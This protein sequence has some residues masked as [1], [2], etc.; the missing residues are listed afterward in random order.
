MDNS[1]LLQW[2]ATFELDGKPSVELKNDAYYNLADGYV[3][4][5][6]LNQI[7][8]VY[9]PD[10][11]LSGIKPV[12]PNGSWPLRVSN[13]NRILQKVDDYASDL[14]DYQL[15]PDAKQL[16]VTVIA[17]NFDSDQV[18]K[19][20]QLILFCAFT[21]D[22]R[23]Y[24]VEKIYHL[25]LKV[26][27]DIK[28]AFEQIIIG[29]KRG[30]TNNRELNSSHA[31]NDSVIRDLK[32]DTG[33]NSSQK[34]INSSPI[35][36]MPAKS[37]GFRG[38]L[39][40]DSSQISGDISRKNESE[41]D[42][43]TH[44]N[45]DFSNETIEE[46]RSR[47][48]AAMIMKDEKS[49]AC[50]DLE[51]K[52]KQLQLEKDLLASENERLSNDKN[53]SKNISSPVN[54][55]S[56][57]RQSQTSARG[58][59]QDIDTRT[60][61]SR[62]K[63]LE[64]DNSNS[65]ILKQ[66]KKLQAELQ[67]LK[68]DMIKIESEKEDFRLKSN[69]LKQDLEKVTLKRDE[70]RQKAELAKRLQDELDEQRHISEK[71]VNHETMIENLVKKNNDLKKELKSIEEKSKSHI[72]EIVE[73]K[74]KN[75]QLTSTLAR[76]DIYKKQLHDAQVTLSEETNRAD[77]AEFELAR[78]TEKYSA[79]R[80]ENEKL[81]ETTNRLMRSGSVVSQ[82]DVGIKDRASVD[83]IETETETQ[84]NN[85]SIVESNVDL[86][87]RNAR[88]EYENKLLQDKLNAKNADQH[89]VLG[90]LLEE[91][92]AK[93]T[94][95]EIENR[96]YRKMIFQLESRLKDLTSNGQYNASASNNVA[97][98][99]SDNMLALMNRVEELQRLLFQKEQEHMEADA[100]Y[101][102]N[103]Q[104]ARDVIKTLNS[105][106]SLNASLH[107]SCV[108]SASPFNSSSL[109]EN[110][111]LKQQLKDREDRLVDM[112]REFYEYKKFKEMHERLIISAFYGLTT[113]MQWKN[114]EKRLERTTLT[115]QPN[116][117]NSSMN[118]SKHS[119]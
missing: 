73:L 64:D 21:C 102:R 43:S 50:H 91:A 40:R 23:Q 115:S 60:I 37:I 101:K 4:A 105:N 98:S 45:Y 110:N 55:V 49:Q 27:L 112:E 65:L 31:S 20:I 39:R 51:L 25:P 95:L 85:L 38:N 69:L 88:L 99:S 114:A 32:A 22:K 46:L 10:S 87:E 11:W 118:H 75:N 71:V 12:P 42:I 24:Y 58:L 26:K 66:N 59:D 103:L 5:R 16:D 80:K 100:K 9:F 116:T 89:S 79:T 117:A 1:S 113:P 17:Q 47:L 41:F 54:L 56:S 15:R 14:Q 76:I 90:K 36:K 83:T 19:L 119:H 53:I 74:E 13:L 86:K 7:S 48:N 106:V 111:L 30:D 97:D 94:K 29:D 70:L 78:L 108:S 109:D 67:R 34:V 44:S 107:P 6:I 8:P 68:E 72:R 77:K 28:E 104:K 2:L 93:C 61:E 81:Y 82:Q 33:V 18:I 3:S 62:L 35:S 57:R 96:N 63:N 92:N 84:A 52:L